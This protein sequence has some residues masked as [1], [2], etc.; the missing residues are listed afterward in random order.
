MGRTEAVRLFIDRLAAARPSFHPTEQNPGAVTNICHRLD[1]IPLALEL[2]AARV[3]AS[4]SSAERL[5]HRF[6]RLVGGDRTAMPRQQTRRA[7]I[8]WCYD[9]LTERRARGG[10]QR[11]QDPVGSRA[12]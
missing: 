6:E 8:D 2:A 10:L 7:A 1:G 12:R 11:R 9:L 3:R 5:S 4:L